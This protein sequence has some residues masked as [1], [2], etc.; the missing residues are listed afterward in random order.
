[1]STVGIDCKC[2]ELGL[3][4]MP[5]SVTEKAAPQPAGIVERLARDDF[6]RKRL[7]FALAPAP[8]GAPLIE[9]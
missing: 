6:D 3:S 5:S 7:N 2:H 8:G 9:A 1:V 4:N